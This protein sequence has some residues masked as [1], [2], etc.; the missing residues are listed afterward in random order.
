MVFSLVSHTRTCIHY[1]W[2]STTLVKYAV[3]FPTFIWALCCTHW[4]RPRNSP[5]PRI[6]AHIRG[7][8]WSA[9]IDDISLWPP[10][11]LEW[12]RHH[13]SNEVILNLID[14]NSERCQA[15]DFCLRVIFKTIKCSA[16]S[17]KD[18][19]SIPLLY[20]CTQLARLQF[21]SA[22]SAHAYFCVSLHFK[23]C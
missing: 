23:K 20:L 13:A 12:S 18:K 14:K 21:V 6:W 1:N 10:Y 11:V 16:N 4:L 15:W 2:V 3:R 5:Y 22:Y 19:L 7:R 17:Y 9:K 8:Y